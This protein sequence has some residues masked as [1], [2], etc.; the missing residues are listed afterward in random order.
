MSRIYFPTFALVWGIA[1]FSVVAG[2][3]RHSTA[4]GVVYGWL[5]TPFSDADVFIFVFIFGRFQVQARLS[6]SLP[7]SDLGKKNS[8]R[9]PTTRT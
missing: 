9:F 6:S 3:L 1:C 5:L 8:D 4:F 7:R 2:V